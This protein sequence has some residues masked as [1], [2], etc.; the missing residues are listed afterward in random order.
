[1]V[2]RE[3]R[4]VGQAGERIFG[5]GL[6]HGYGT[7]GQ[8]PGIETGIGGNAG[9]AISDEDAQRKI[10]AFGCVDAFHLAE[11]DGNG[12]RSGSHGDRI[13]L[14]GTRLFGEADEFFGTG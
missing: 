13:C 4:I 11:A 9:D 10:V 5:R 8:R 1:M 12:P 6:C 2:V 3:I 7:L 14:G